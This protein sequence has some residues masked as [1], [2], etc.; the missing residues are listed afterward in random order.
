MYKKEQIQT[1]NKKEREREGENKR[2]YRILFC[3]YIDL[4]VA[5]YPGFAIY[6]C[7]TLTRAFFSIYARV[8]WWKAKN[9]KTSSEQLFLISTIVDR[10]NYLQYE[11]IDND[12]SST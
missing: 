10:Y 8:Y 9:K 11:F 4:F 3:S 12:S 6:P 1:E 5:S 7:Q 2:I